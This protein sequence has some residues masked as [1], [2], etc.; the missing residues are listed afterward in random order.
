MNSAPGPIGVNMVRKLPSLV[1][2]ALTAAFIAASLVTTVSPALATIFPVEGGKGERGEIVTCPEGFLLTGFHGAAGKWI[3]RI[4]LICT[5]FRPP[6]YAAGGVQRLAPRGGPGG[7]LIEQYCDTDGAIRLLNLSIFEEGHLVGRTPKVVWKI[8]F[9][10]S[11]PKDGS[12]AGVRAFLG[13]NEVPGSGSDGIMEVAHRCPGN[14]Y[15]TGLS[16]RYGR[17]V[18]G[19]GLVCG[20]APVNS[21]PAVSAERID[22]GMENDTN[23]PFSDFDRFHINDNR[24]DRC[25]SEC[26]LRKDRCKAWTYVR[27]GFQ[28]EYAVCYL[29]NAVPRPV[30][31]KCCISGVLPS[32]SRSGIAQGPGG[33]APNPGAPPPSAPSPS[34]QPPSLPTQPSPSAPQPGPAPDAPARCLSGFVWREARPT[35]YVCVTPESRAL[36]RQENASA[37]SRWD[38]NGAYGP[39]TCIAGFV[40]REAFDGDTVCVTPA[41]RAEVKEENRLAPTRRE[42]TPRRQ[43]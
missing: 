21:G 1:K 3:D 19:L 20:P 35:D 36:V 25:Q 16:I 10:C 14:E 41:R 42:W 30:S 7:G 22:P 31:D 6:N 33:F 40:W 9:A 39:N 8:D 32:K 13:I 5:E 29:K 28:H 26:L 24:P 17:D 4:G 34:D 18:N 2:G 11:R 12:D 27:P 23:R 43:F 37:P 38:P 15:A